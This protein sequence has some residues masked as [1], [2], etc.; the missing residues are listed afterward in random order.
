VFRSLNLLLAG[1]TFLAGLIALGWGVHQERQWAI[2]LRELQRRGVQ[3]RAA[4]VHIDNRSS[5]QGNYVTYRFLPVGR[6]E[7]LPQPRFNPA[8]QPDG[9]IDADQTIEQMRQMQE[10]SQKALHY[11]SWIWGE[12]RISSATRDDIAAHGDRLVTYLPDAPQINVIGKLTDA[13][14]ASEWQSNPI[15]L[16]VAIYLGLV[17][18]IAVARRATAKRTEAS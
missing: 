6:P 16:A 14:I 11:H 13:R 3:V 5:H 12:C 9:S 18:I 4:E 8:T 10:W 17:L 7:M 1:L 15:F 2:T